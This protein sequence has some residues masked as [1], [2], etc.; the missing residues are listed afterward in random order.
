MSYSTRSV[1]AATVA[2]LMAGIAVAF[3][4]STKG[5]PVHAH[6][7]Q[8]HLDNFERQAKLLAEPKEGYEY[9]GQMGGY[10]S[11]QSND[12]QDPANPTTFSTAGFSCSVSIVP[13]EAPKA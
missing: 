3:N 12:N 8:A 6:D 4:E 1:R 5:Q 13:V 11:W 10:L 2:A 7:R 9:Q